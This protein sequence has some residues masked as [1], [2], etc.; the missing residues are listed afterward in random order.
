MSAELVK[1]RFLK[2]QPFS[3]ITKEPPAENPTPALGFWAVGA[4]EPIKWVNLFA[5]VI[6]VVSEVLPVPPE[7]TIKITSCCPEVAP[8]YASAT[9]FS[10]SACD[11]PDPLSLPPEGST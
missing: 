9:V 7:G 5:Q 8:S 4:A 2:R 3:E 1:V 6:A 10:A 11:L